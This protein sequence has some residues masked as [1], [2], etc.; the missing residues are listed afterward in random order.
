MVNIRVT[1]EGH[2]QKKD[3]ICSR[4]KPSD[5]DPNMCRLHPIRDE[6]FKCSTEANG[7]WCKLKIIAKQVTLF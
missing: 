7:N 5:D 4:F 1:Y 3:K 6:Q 2:T